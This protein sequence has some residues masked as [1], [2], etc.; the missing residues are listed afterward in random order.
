MRGIVL[1]L[2]AGQGTRLGCGPKG[3]VELAGVPL[4]VLAAERAAAASLVDGIV[5]AVPPG[6]ED[7]A[8]AL[9]PDADVV[10]GGSS[11]QASAS[12]ALAAAGDT[13]AV[14]VHDAARALCP[15]EVFDRCLAALDGAEA[16]IPAMPV[17]D[18]VKDVAADVVVSTLD[19]ARLVSVQT[20][21][22]FLAD[23][24]RRAHEVARGDGFDGT[25]DA[26]LVERIGVAVRVVVG[27]PLAMKI[28]T[29][30]DLRVAEALL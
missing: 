16:V 25:D 7:A 3:F 10:A 28:T 5:V 24:Y 17:G 18:T 22:A 9:L 19:R 29:A 26:S 2:A 23:V 8:R 21:Q 6:T 20:P 30:H 15:A 27:D 13:D 12:L 14:A 1:L 4:V 11:R